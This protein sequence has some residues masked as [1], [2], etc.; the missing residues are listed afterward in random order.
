[1][2]VTLSQ[3]E[4]ASFG[5]RPKDKTGHG[6]RAALTPGDSGQVL[7]RSF[8]NRNV[9]HVRMMVRV[10]SLAGGPIVVAR[11]LNEQGVITFSLTLVNANTVRLESLG[12]I[13]ISANLRAAPT[14]VWECVEISINGNSQ[15]T[16]LWINGIHAAEAVD[17]DPAFNV[18]S[19]EFGVPVKHTDAQ[20]EIHLDEIAVG[21]DYLG[22]VVVTPVSEFAHDPARWLVI[23]NTNDADSSVWADSYRQTRDVPNANLLGLNL[24][25]DE[26][27]DFAGYLNLLTQIKTYL[28][29]NRLRQQ[30][31]GILLGYRVPGYVDHPSLD[32]QHP[33]GSLLHT[34]AD[35]LFAATN[36]VAAMEPVTRPSFTNLKGVRLTARIDA[37]SPE[38]AAVFTERANAIGQITLNPEDRLWVDA[39]PKF[40]AFAAFAERLSAWFKGFD[41]QRLRIEAAISEPPADTTGIGFEAIEHDA[42]YWGWSSPTPPPNF[43]GED[44]GPRVVCAQLRQPEVTSST[45]RSAEPNNWI[46]SAI[47][48]GYAAAIASAHNTSISLLPIAQRFFE[49]LRRGWTLAEAWVVAQPFLRG[50]LHLVGDPLMT[51][52]TPQ[53]G[54]DV[55][56]PLTR[57][58]DLDPDSPLAVTPATARRFALQADQF[59]ETG[60]TAHYLIRQRDHAGRSDAVYQPLT[61]D[62]N[63]GIPSDPPPGP[64]WPNAD[65]W[66]VKFRGTQAEAYLVFAGRLS[67]LPIQRIDWLDD[68]G[69]PDVPVE[70]DPQA[71]FAKHTFTPGSIATRYRWRLTSPSGV[72]RLTPWSA[73]IRKKAQSAVTLTTL[74]Y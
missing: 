46:E 49:A 47:D 10:D 24:P 33:I 27:I 15:D 67:T 35:H 37:A 74:E 43:F 6:L 26:V 61:I 12:G 45:L 28:D 18:T 30:I 42:F 60:N 14:P 63:A 29:L 40:P 44:H 66:A 69:S 34:D 2:G 11:G 59:P 55:F 8:A 17:I 32:Q 72:V 23:Y 64:A 31:L 53:Q 3:T 52:R 38:R 50:G 70:F 16:S 19:L 36:P 62:S 7:S 65:D 22:P 48:A 13:S 4:A 5:D 56:G 54:W 58:E 68:S 71:D 25:T 73:P 20:G 1:M 39:I 9:I 21:D 57:S 41:R 51:V